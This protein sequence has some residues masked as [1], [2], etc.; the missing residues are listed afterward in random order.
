MKLT[1]LIQETLQTFLKIK[2]KSFMKAKF[3]NIK[4]NSS[5]RANSRKM[6]KFKIFKRSL[7]KLT[8]VRQLAK[9]QPDTTPRYL[10]FN[11]SQV[12]AKRQMM[13][14]EKAK[15][16]FIKFKIRKILIQKQIGLKTLIKKKSLFKD[17]K[18]KLILEIK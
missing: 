7:N 10:K 6:K 1:N 9:N 11:K 17:R 14:S 2:L 4:G 5:N 16:K 8:W 12:Q 13:K 15:L 18:L 3:Q